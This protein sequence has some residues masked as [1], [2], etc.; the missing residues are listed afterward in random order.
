MQLSFIRYL[1]HTHFST[2]YKISKKI[3]NVSTKRRISNEA[4]DY[5]RFQINKN[6]ELILQ[7]GDITQ[8]S[9]DAIVNAGIYF[10]CTLNLK[11]L[12]IAKPT[13]LGGGGVDGGKYLT[14][15]SYN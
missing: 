12:I 4:M 3:T 7:R 10:L 9:G 5:H 13:L 11:Y 6:A 8:W 15:N 1:R 2:C 14:N